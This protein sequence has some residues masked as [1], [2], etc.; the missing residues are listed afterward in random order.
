MRCRFVVKVTDVFYF[1]VTGAKV[2]VA[3]FPTPNAS[4][5]GADFKPIAEKGA[6]VHPTGELDVATFEVNITHPDFMAAHQKGLVQAGQG[7]ALPK[8]IFGAQNQL[9][10]QEVPSYDLVV[11]THDGG[12][13]VV[14]LY[15]AL[16]RLLDTTSDV[17]ARAQFFARNPSLGKTVEFIDPG[18]QAV[19]VFSQTGLL[20]ADTSKGPFAFTKQLLRITGKSHYARWKPSA[21]SLS[22]TRTGR[23][24]VAIYDPS[25]K[26][27]NKKPRSGLPQEQPINYHVFFHPS[28]SWFPDPDYPLG[29]W[30]LDMVSRYVFSPQVSGGKKAMANQI[31]SAGKLNTVLIFPVGSGTRWHND[32]LTQDAVMRLVHEVNYFIQRRDGVRYPLQPVGAV[33][34]SA[35]SSAV[36]FITA[37]LKSRPPRF[38]SGASIREVFDLDGR[39]MVNNRVSQ[40]EMV[41]YG[42]LLRSW[43]LEDISVRAVRSYSQLKEPF[44]ALQ[45]ADS[46][47]R[48]TVANGCS[49]VHSPSVTCLFAPLPAWSFFFTEP[50]DPTRPIGPDNRPT[51]DRD[52]F[53]GHPDFMPVHDII[54]A[55]FLEHAMS[56]SRH[57]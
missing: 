32:L 29:A 50:T 11:H 54:P 25:T 49:F 34:I 46:T 13:P 18:N 22:D 16:C 43:L 20:A 51:I 15:I 2:D 26:F 53:A 28:T 42:R 12:V 24:M 21:D 35:Y 36:S 56:V 23:P 1:P 3:T 52:A 30:W 45:N 37:I 47:A 7:N 8:A 33:G 41:R 27:T 38:Q 55:W 14:E 10:E 19:R 17:K 6:G 44:D 40:A 31:H 48:L 5:S 39:T 4:A 9:F 57:D